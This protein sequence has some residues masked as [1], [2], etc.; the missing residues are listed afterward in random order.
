MYVDRTAFKDKF[1]NFLIENK[2]MN[3]ITQKAYYPPKGL[4]GRLGF[5]PIQGGQYVS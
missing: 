1:N 2:E 5:L 3:T 4:D